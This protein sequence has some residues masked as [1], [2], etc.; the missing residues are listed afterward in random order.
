M[1]GGTSLDGF[2]KFNVIDL[3]TIPGKIKHFPWE[4]S[5]HGWLIMCFF[6]PHSYR[7]RACVDDV[8]KRVRSGIVKQRWM[9]RRYGVPTS[10]AKGVCRRA[11][12]YTSKR[13]EEERIVGAHKQK[14]KW[15]MNEDIKWSLTNWTQSRLYI[16]ETKLREQREWSVD[17]VEIHLLVSTNDLA[18]SILLRAWTVPERTQHACRLRR[19]WKCQ[20]KGWVEN[21]YL[22]FSRGKR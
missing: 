19:G 1:K 21:W 15:K 7:K 12:E 16:V 13:A 11:L 5:A 17:V 10:R 6:W 14:S 2:R 20:K 22:V 3:A 9:H 4:L 8:V 18:G